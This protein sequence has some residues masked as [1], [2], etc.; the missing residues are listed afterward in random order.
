LPG[1]RAR[2]RAW[3]SHDVTIVFLANLTA[4]KDKRNA[5]SELGELTLAILGRPSDAA[6]ATPR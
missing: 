2:R 6:A 1:H 3:S 5:A 4:T